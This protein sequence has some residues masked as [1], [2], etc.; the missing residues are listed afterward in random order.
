MFSF[1]KRPDKES[2][3]VAARPSSPISKSGK[4]SGPDLRGPMPLPQVTEGNE[5]SDWAMWEDSVLEQDSQMMHSQFHD[6]VPSEFPHEQHAEDAKPGD[7]DPFAT[8]G[9]HAA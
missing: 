3:P 7:V 9:K 8:V 6:T 4:Y 2:H 5:D 1:F